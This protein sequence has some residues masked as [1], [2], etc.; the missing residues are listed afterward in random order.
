M[1]AAKR[2][3]TFADYANAVS[4]KGLSAS[5]VNDS[6]AYVKDSAKGKGRGPA[7]AAPWSRSVREHGR[8][9][10]EDSHSL[11]HP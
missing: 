5:G 10:S 1:S 9:F 11:C 6:R 4:R 2:A 8:N 3:L 7:R